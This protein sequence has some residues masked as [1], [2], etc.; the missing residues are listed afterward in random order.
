MPADPIRRAR[1]PAPL[2]LALLALLAAAP[3][4]GQ[5]SSGTTVVYEREVFQYPRAGRPDPFRSLLLDGDL[6]IRIEDLA[7]RGVL[8]HDDPSQS[9]AV[10]TLRGSDRRIQLR[11]GERVGPLRV[12]AIHPERVEIVLEELGVARR[13]TLEI[14]RP[15]SGGGQ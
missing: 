12:L 1:G 5:A 13:E 8:H 7:L 6:G 14:Q 11:I 4:A 10:V 2:L 3:V 15:R 9:V